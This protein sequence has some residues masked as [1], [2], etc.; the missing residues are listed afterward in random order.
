VRTICIL[1]GALFISVLASPQ[2]IST[3]QINGTVRDATGLA[4]PGADVKA[5]QTATGLVRSTTTGTDGGFVLI[6]MPIGPYQLEVSKEGFSKFLQ[7]GIILQVG[8]NPNIEVALKVGSVSEQVVVEANANL[9]E[10]RNAGVGTV[11]ENQRVLELPLNGRQATDLIYLSGMATQVNGAGLNSGVRNYPTVDISVAGGLSNGLTYA[12]DGA[13]HNDPYNNLNLPLPFPDA[14]Q[15]FKLETSALPA[16]YGHHSAAA[17][18]IVTKSGSN[19]FHGDLFEFFRNGNL[20]ALNFFATTPDFLKRN[21]FGGTFGGPIK[22]DRLFFFVGQQTTIT[23]TTPSTSVAYVPTAQML[24]GDF[25]AVASAACTT[26]GRP[27]TLASPFVGNKVSPA[28]FSQPSVNILNFSAFPHTGDPCGKIQYASHLANNDYNSLARVDYQLSEK[29]ALFGR[30]SQ[31]H[32]EQPTD[33]DPANILALVNANLDFWVHSFV[34]GD[35]YSISAGTV[36]NF[37]GVF[38]RSE[39]PKSPAQYFD[40]HDVGINMW[41]A[42]PKFMRLAIPGG[43]NIAGT[44]ATPSTYNTTGFQFS[45][46][47][48]MVR[49]A[50]QIGVGADWIKS[51]LTGTSLLNA[52]G[53]FTFNGQVTGLGLADFMLGQPSSFT[54]AGGPSLAYQRMNY[55]GL[56]VQDSW[57]AF[58]R[59]TLSGGIRWDPNLP[60]YTK[61]GWT[62]HFDPALFA[63]GVRSSQYT[64]APA[65]L[66]FPGDPGYPGKSVSNKRFNNF[67]PRVSVAWDPQGNGR[68]SV[69]AA[70]GIFYDLPAQDNY[71]GF[72]QAPPFSSTTTIPY[73]TTFVPGEFANP[74]ANQ[75]GGNPYPLNISRDTPFIKFGSYENFLL[76]PRTT[77]S[78]Q[79][80]LSLQR[81]IGVDWLVQA[82]Y[83]GTHIVHLW[84]GNQINPGVYI[85][86]SSTTGNLNNR[87]ILNLLNPVEGSF[88]GSIAQLD[89]GGNLSYNGLVLSLQKRAAKGLTAQVNYTWSH[90]IS[91]NHNPELAVAGLNFMIPGNRRADRS[92]CPLGDRRHV[93]NLSAV[94]QTPR[95]SGSRW[96]MLARDWQISGI[97]RLQTGPYFGVTTG[98][99]QALTGQTTYERP[100]QMLL[101]PYLPVQSHSAFLN[102]AAFAQPTSS[103]YGNMGANSILAPGFI[104]IDMGLV[105]AFPIREGKD[106][107]FRA[108]AF[109][110]PNHV[111]PDVCLSGFGVIQPCTPM[112]TA[113]NTPTFGRIQAAKDPRILQLALKFM[114]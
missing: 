110:L 114:F 23:R 3:S 83:L 58:S 113:L 88:Y 92:N 8:S 89:D 109:N 98:I 2:A 94:Y 16:Q 55:V 22:K 45:E 60:A 52:T 35:T 97:V 15:E 26:S 6:N 51:F 78:Q 80:N 64:Y 10:T 19:G 106:L 54:Q 57:K 112:S 104:Q 69:R 1:L 86:G 61:Y 82:N 68:M 29:H 50:H 84:G 81:Q 48:S 25:T 27:I 107:Q 62:S 93:F 21:Q 39:I 72:A 13:T 32:L 111:N 100:N 42:V 105:R 71:V 49:G 30:Y 77:Y 99:D 102:P 37:R 67:A 59:L 101:S 47:I 41:V 5:T 46:D 34:L 85:P 87:R 73:P 53:P 63:Q 56:Y 79:W 4:A 17:V 38:N 33:Y 44:N 66:I 28:L 36:S 76:D 108:E 70:Y 9:V 74:W 7:S 11:M 90:C 14:L 20:N 75:P 103:T 18:N 24:Q 40:A 12:L 95:F 91:D 43:F 96:S 65:G 31:A